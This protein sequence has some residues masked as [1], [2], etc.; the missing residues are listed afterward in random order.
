MFKFQLSA[1][2]LELAPNNDKVNDTERCCIACGLGWAEK[3]KNGII[4]FAQADSVDIHKTEH[5]PTLGFCL[6]VQSEHLGKY[7]F[8]IFHMNLHISSVKEKSEISYT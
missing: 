8:L 6:T 7:F 1:E 5:Y 2:N 4:N 3:R